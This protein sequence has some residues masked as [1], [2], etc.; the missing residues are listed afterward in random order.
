[1][2]NKENFFKTKRKELHMTQNEVAELLGVTY[3]TI[4]KWERGLTIPQQ[5]RYLEVAEV[6]HC[7]I[8]D[9]VNA[10]S[11]VKEEAIER[12]L[13][14]T[15]TAIETLIERKLTEGEVDTLNRIFGENELFH[16]NGSMRLKSVVEIPK[17]EDDVYQQL[18]AVNPDYSITQF[19]ASRY[20]SVHTSHTLKNVSLS[21]NQN[22]RGTSMDKDTYNPILSKKM[23]KA[24][25]DTTPGTNNFV[26]SEIFISA[27]KK[28]AVILSKNYSSS[29]NVVVIG[30]AGAGKTHAFIR[31]N[32]ES[33]ASNMGNMVIIGR[34]RELC[35]DKKDMLQANGYE[36][37][38]FS[39]EQTAGTVKFNPLAHI[40]DDE[41][42]IA[43]STQLLENWQNKTD[44]FWS[45]ASKKYLA[46]FIAC[47]LEAITEPTL[48]DVIELL[49][50]PEHE[51]T[52]IFTRL[53]RSEAGKRIL[54]QYNDFCNSM[55]KKTREAIRIDIMVQLHPY[56]TEQMRDLLS[57]DTLD[58][59]K[60]TD[61]AQALFLDPPI[62]DRTYY[63][64]IIILLEQIIRTCE[65][66]REGREG[67]RQLWFLLDEFTNLGLFYDIDKHVARGR[68][69]DMNYC[70]ILQSL[71]QLMRVYP[72][73]WETILD[74][75]ESILCLGTSDLVSAKYI[76]K[77]SGL[78]HKFAERPVLTPEDVINL[79]AEQ[80]IIIKPRESAIID[81]KYSSKRVGQ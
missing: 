20:A 4:S 16:K 25:K 80:C 65:R 77:N 13:Y 15:P 9:I 70:I 40:V 61:T 48:Y 8:E 51:I 19:L 54:H 34:K 42:I 32:I 22:E 7:T 60:F 53:N 71:D 1:M 52:S 6:Y 76:S 64:L 56:T 21:V 50:K 18:R 67:R 74:N 23:D 63:G 72:V 14:L 38:E 58:F 81:E 55:N 79:P 46:L 73:S 69:Y 62:Y 66:E 28:S 27:G 24:V 33:I 75:T 45:K 68:A 36:V 59:S 26:N 35:N 12:Q 31:P 41:D 29:G 11:P 37:N 2:Q 10:T 39:L 17:V 30:D 57:G 5:D 3:Q 43:L 44:L 78:I 49:Q 47:T